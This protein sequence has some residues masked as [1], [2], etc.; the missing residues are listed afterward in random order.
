[1]ALV[2]PALVAL[3]LLVLVGYAFAG[4]SDRI[5]S[6]VKIAGV[7][8]GGLTSAQARQKLEKA[9]AKRSWVPVK[10]LA[11]DKQ[12]E[13]APAQ[14]GIYIDWGAAIAKARRDGDG[15][16]PLRGFKR[17]EMRLLG[18]RIKPPSKLSAPA[19]KKLLKMIATSVDKPALEPSL[20]LDG[21]QPRVIPGR[22]GSALDRTQAADI[23]VKTLESL[24]RGT[25][26]LPVRT[27]T[28]SVSRSDLVRVAGQVRTVASAPV[29]LNLGGVALEDPCAAG[30]ED[31]R[32]PARRRAKSEHRREGGQGLPGHA[33]KAARS[34]RQERHLRDRRPKHSRRSLAHRSRARP[35]KDRRRD[36]RRGASSAATGSPLWF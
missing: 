6:G 5:A 36:S 4:S 12:F 20:V 14:L 32:V 11:K 18:N 8:V 22:T 21:S 26:V 24:S 1:M 33:R 35:G 19:L 27:L 23:V 30:E 29:L 25:V 7:D 2:A 3:S 16:G 34:A 15:V 31:A 13:V 28:P 17:L 9:S 10:F